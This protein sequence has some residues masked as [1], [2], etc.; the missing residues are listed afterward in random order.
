MINLK[1]SQ[2]RHYKSEY[3]YDAMMLV[4]SGL[5]SILILGCAIFEHSFEESFYK[6]FWWKITKDDPKERSGYKRLQNEMEFDDSLKT[7]VIIKG[8]PDYIHV[9]D[10]DNV[11]LAY[12]EE[13]IFYHFKR[14][15]GTDSEQIDSY[16][17]DEQE[18]SESMIKGLKEIDI[19]QAKLGETGKGPK[20]IKRIIPQGTDYKEYGKKYAIVIGISDY[21]ELKPESQE[22]D[23]TRLF[24]LQYADDDAR[25]FI[26]FL[27][28]KEKSGGDWVIYSFIGEKAKTEDIRRKLDDVL[29]LC[30]S[31]DL[32]YIFFSGH[33]RSTPYDPSEIYLLTCDF[34]YEDYYDG[35]PYSWL[36]NKIEESPAEHIISFID[37]C[38]S[39]TIGFAR[40]GANRPDTRFMGELSVTIPNKVIFT[41]GRGSQQ[42]FECDKLRNG[43]FSY[44]LVEGLNGKAQD[45]DNDSFVDLSELSDYVEDKVKSYTSLKKKMNVQIPTLWERKGLI[46]NDFP[47]AISD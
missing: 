29:T 24:D 27:K 31:I 2:R 9:I 17:F 1:I 40:G 34:K 12:V 41:S 19:A 16:S 18:L 21:K 4:L 44:F 45:V 15:W 13:G 20:E 7:F 3:F 39:G 28:S 23:K 38:R 33:G 26:K 10:L 22:R 42:A 6:G 30:K 5:I 37:A 47:L 32:L 11:E 35:I 46:A 25:D 8:L 14:G 36:R 43:V